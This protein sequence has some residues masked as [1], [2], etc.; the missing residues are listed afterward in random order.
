MQSKQHIPDLA[1]LMQC[2]AIY[3]EASRQ[4]PIAVNVL[5]HNCLPEQEVLMAFMDHISAKRRLTPAKQTG[6]KLTAASMHNASRAC[7]WCSV[8]TSMDHIK[9]TCPYRSADD[10]QGPKRP[11]TKPSYRPPLSAL[12]SRIAPLERDF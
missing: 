10:P 3:D 8:C 12:N 11:M 2:F 1:T 9:A 6:P 5:S 7:R 4:G